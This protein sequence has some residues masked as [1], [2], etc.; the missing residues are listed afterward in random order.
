M[1]NQVTG[2]Q[3]VR[4][5]SIS[6]LTLLFLFEPSKT[7]DVHSTVSGTSDEL[8]IVDCLIPG[9]T[10]R[11]GR[12]MVY[13]TARRSIKT[14]AEECAISGGEYVLDE[15]KSYEVALKIWLPLAKKGDPKA[16]N[17]VGE[18]YEKGVDGKPN[19]QEAAKWY[20]IAADNGYARAQI[21]L[22]NFYEQGL[23]LQ[24]DKEKAFNLYREASGMEEGLSIIS[25]EEYE[26]LIIENVQK[27]S[28]IESLKKQLD[29]INNRLNKSK[30][31]LEQ[32]EQGVVIEKRKLEE[33]KQ[34]LEDLKKQG[35]TNK[36]IQLTEKSKE[37]R[38][39][40]IELA[41]LQNR[42]KHLETEALK[43]KSQLANAPQH[44]V[45]KVEMEKEIQISKEKYKNLNNQYKYTKTELDQRRNEAL[46][47]EYELTEA[48]SEIQNKQNQLEG[49]SLEIA[50]LETQLFKQDDVVRKREEQI[51]RLNQQIK[52]L[53][54]QKITINENKGKGIS[55]LGP[56]ITMI[57]PKIDNTRGV[58]VVKSQGNIERSIIG[59][60]EAPAGLMSFTFNGVNVINNINKESG[61][62]HLKANVNSTDL[63]VNLVAVDNE[64]KR[65]STDFLLRPEVHYTAL[66][67][68]S[69]ESESSIMD[70]GNFYAL[71]IGN[72]DYNHW[73]DLQTPENDANVIE[74]ILRVKYGFK[75]EVILNA[76]RSDI[77]NAFNKYRKQMTENDNL[78]IYYAGH[79]Y[80]DKGNEQGF[81]IPI[82]GELDNDTQ[83]IPNTRIADYLEAIK[84]RNIL[85]ISDSCYAGTL[86]RDS[87]PKLDADKIGEERLKY[88]HDL[89]E[90]RSRMVLTSGDIEPVL[91][92]GGGGHSI[93]AKVLI[94]LL[95]ANNDIVEGL[96]LYVMLKEQVGYNAL[97]LTRTQ[98]PQY[99]PIRFAGYE[100]GD[101][102][103]VPKKL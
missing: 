64:G 67:E 69:A 84:A 63:P 78:L 58:N 17:Y 66:A 60:I 25:T 65:A 42:I 83:W 79:G 33:T 80:L 38:D 101:F 91:D 23:G 28:E 52:D 2:I 12:K 29:E 39:K 41:K 71:I 62:F 70:F 74:K 82:D 55:P 68:D 73:S 54:T 75:T 95:N 5:I 100:T 85:V 11:L 15:G 18:I 1:I 7:N 8:F 32:R 59:K 96:K 31:E 98:T 35:S 44:G 77:L 50:K 92:T 51:S 97:R 76:N 94:N 99:A 87:I 27:S 48:Q 61:L 3:F 22:G 21:N 40:T 26:E 88:L 45:E 36:D 10:R 43:Y 49:H 9:Q 72:N 103:F 13:Q 90:A 20:Q 53:E 37:V 46:T 30:S 4:I 89:W 24:Q 47:L 16:Q 81:W 102:V 93:F 34:K 86:T 6:I 57:D 19:Y 14:T 56:I